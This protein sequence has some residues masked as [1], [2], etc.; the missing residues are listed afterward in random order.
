MT[1]RL[2]APFFALVLSVALFPDTASA[3]QTETFAYRLQQVWSTSFRLIR[4]DMGFKVTDRDDS[5]GFLMFEYDDGE[6]TY[7]GSLQ[8]VEVK[9][10]ERDMVRAEVQIPQQPSYIE[11]MILQKLS[12]KLRA[13]YGDPPSAAPPAP[14]APPKKDEGDK[15]D[16]DKQPEGDKSAP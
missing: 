1:R 2:A 3:K 5:V 6:R 13:E 16:P 4:V 14:E 7:P 12:K 15:E 9:E 8:L 10:G 11:L